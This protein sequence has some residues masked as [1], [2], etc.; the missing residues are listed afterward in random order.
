MSK[1]YSGYYPTLVALISAL[2]IAF[3]APQAAAAQDPESVFAQQIILEIEAL[4]DAALASAMPGKQAKQ[5]NNRLRVSSFM[6]TQAATLSVA[7]EVD[8]GVGKN[9]HEAH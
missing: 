8:A 4:Q 1:Q 3:T 5:I 9:W 2:L 6:P 7:L